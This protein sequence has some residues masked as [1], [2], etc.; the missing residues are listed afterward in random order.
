MDD[1]ISGNVSSFFKSFFFFIVSTLL[2]NK[3]H[4]G[5]KSWGEVFQIWP[6]GLN[7]FPKSIWDF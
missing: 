6:P 5:R 4:G 7:Q 2:L 1:G 3:S